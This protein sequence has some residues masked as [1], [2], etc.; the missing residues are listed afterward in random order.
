MSIS[1]SPP[2]PSVR[3]GPYYLGPFDKLMAPI[4]AAWA[5]DPHELFWLAPKTYPPLTAAKVVGWPGSD[6]CP[7]LFYRDGIVEPIGYLELNPMP[8]ERE[9]LWLGHCV[10]APARRGSGL[11][12]V[13]INLVLEEAFQTRKAA[14][15][16][17][18]V[19]PDNIAAI[20]CYRACGF[21]EVGEQVKY[22]PTT[23]RQHRMLQMSVT[24]VDHARHVAAG[25]PIR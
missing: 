25:K 16:S 10:V 19:F 24:R 14:R 1:P 17:L 21:T 2:P 11:G 8:G 15:V 20:R 23:G 3:S 18:V 6:G 12:E 4:V 5:R 9:H 13:M 7:L 22:F